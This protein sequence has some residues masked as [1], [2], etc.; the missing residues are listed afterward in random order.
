MSLDTTYPS[1]FASLLVKT[2]QKFEKSSMSKCEQASNQATERRK[3]DNSYWKY[4]QEKEMIECRKNWLVL[5]QRRRKHGCNVVPGLEERFVFSTLYP[6]I[7]QLYGIKSKIPKFQIQ[8][9]QR[10]L[11]GCTIFWPNLLANLTNFWL[12][13]LSNMISFQLWAETNITEKFHI[14]NFKSQ[15]LHRHNSNPDTAILW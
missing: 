5:Y 6:T 13:L 15:P 10:L 3:K 9:A 2:K 1:L 14:L 11:L 4:W 12:T 8:K 7:F